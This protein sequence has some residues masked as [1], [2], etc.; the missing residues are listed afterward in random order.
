M[1]LTVTLNAALDITHHVDRLRPHAA[2]RVH[3]VA[4]RAGGK[5]VNVSRVLHALGRPTL[6]TGLAGGATG[7]AVRREL[8]R[9]GLAEEL[10]PVVGET[11]RTVAV[12][13]ASTG[14]TTT[15]LEPGPVVLP[16]EWSLFRDAFGALLA[17]ATVVVLSGSLPPGLPDDAYAVLVRAARERGV[18]ALLD[19]SGPALLAALP[20]GPALV[21]PNADELAEVAARFAAAAGAGPDPG[22]DGPHRAALPAA[23]A[24]LSAGAEAVVASLGAAGMVAVTAEG[25]WRA[26]PPERL[27]GNPTGAGD[28]AVAALAVG[29]A[30]RDPWPLR[31]AEAVA[32]SAAAVAAP[33][34]GSFEPDVHHRLRHL[35][36]VAPLPRTPGDTPCPS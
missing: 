33:L 23:E 14:D 26:R 31:L 6:V 7:A 22:P 10:I 17:R 16:E 13:D 19:T 5:G 21:K 1:I 34:A 11:R 9:A 8:H 15:L 35:V 28:A 18:P 25:A 30:A 12:V 29:L 2:H 32:L 27:R 24:L 20:A 36:D 4:A 3:G